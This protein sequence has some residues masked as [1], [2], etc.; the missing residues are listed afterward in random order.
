MFA[1][2]KFILAS[3][4]LSR[5]KILKNSGFVFKQIKPNCNEEVIKKKLV[6]KKISPLNF[7]KRLSYEKAISISKKEKYTE[8]VVIGCDTI[9]CLNNKIFDKAKNMNQAEKKIT[10]LSGRTHKIISGLTVCKNGRKIWDCSETTK[11]TIRKL[12]KSQIKTYLKMSGREILNSV[13]CY[14][15]ELLGTNIIENI[16]GDFFNVMGLPL[17]KFLKYIHSIK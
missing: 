9:I 12:N 1:H 14:Q 8:H 10:E 17:F 15:I 7:A 4:S 13:G 11:V 2:N 6:T 3:S 16:K 5:R